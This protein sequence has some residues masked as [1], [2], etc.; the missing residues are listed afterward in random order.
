MKLVKKL[1]MIAIITVAVVML[2]FFAQSNNQNVEL[3]LIFHKFESIQIWLLVLLSFLTGILFTILVVLV[4]VISVKYNEGKLIKENR[5]LIEELS[6]IRKQQ[7]ADL[8]NLS[9]EKKSDSFTA[10]VVDD[11]F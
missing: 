8:E 9:F 10:G 2:S 11:R 5:K 6:K 4:D 7:L 1:F 3:N